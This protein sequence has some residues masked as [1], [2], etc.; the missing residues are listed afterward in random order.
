MVNTVCSTFI[1][2]IT[3]TIVSMSGLRQNL[4]QKV[5]NNYWII[6]KI[7]KAHVIIKASKTINLF[8]PPAL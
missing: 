6:N 1:L 5:Y 4:I 8:V 3:A 7:G 2:Y